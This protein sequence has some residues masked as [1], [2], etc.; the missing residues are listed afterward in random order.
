[1]KYYIRFFSKKLYTLYIYFTITNYTKKLSI[2]F[3]KM[4][5][6]TKTSLHLHIF[7]LK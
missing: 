5:T 6:F 3:D 2:S 7:P 1:M 4:D